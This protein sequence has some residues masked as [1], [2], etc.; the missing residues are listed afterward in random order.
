MH[1]SSDRRITVGRSRSS[2]LKSNGRRISSLT[3]SIPRSSRAA[4]GSLVRSMTRI[5]I[6]FAVLTVCTAA[7]STTVIE[8]RSTSCRS[9]M[10]VSVR[11]IAATFSG[12]LSRMMRGTV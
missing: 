1:S 12:P 11:S 6:G 5:V 10:V 2:R 8:V 9:T 4:S 3:V 7:P